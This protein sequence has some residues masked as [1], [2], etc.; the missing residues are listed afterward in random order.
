MNWTV[1]AALIY[2]KWISKPA[3]QRFGSGEMS[4]QKNTKLQY[5]DIHLPG[6]NAIKYINVWMS[7]GKID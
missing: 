3:E 6:Q 4:K 1:S 7:G 5:H 2:N